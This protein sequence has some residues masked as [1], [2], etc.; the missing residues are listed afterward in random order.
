VGV[1]IFL[2]PSTHLPPIISSMILFTLSANMFFSFSSMCVSPYS[3][4]FFSPRV[5]YKPLQ[6][7]ETNQFAPKS[8][9]LGF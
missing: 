9:L 7:L 4:G 3:A 2:V 8:S 6:F 5:T 1:D